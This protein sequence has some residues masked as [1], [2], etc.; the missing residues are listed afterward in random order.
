MA[1]QRPMSRGT[2]A[3]EQHELSRKWLGKRE[4]HD[5]HRACTLSANGNL[6]AA[7][8]HGVKLLFRWERPHASFTSGIQWG[9]AHEYVREAITCTPRT[10]AGKSEACSERAELAEAKECFEAAGVHASQRSA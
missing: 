9:R 1:A 5:I 2:R 4:W 3:G 8:I 10:R 7:E 6:Y